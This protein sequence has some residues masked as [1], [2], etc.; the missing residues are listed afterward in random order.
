MVIYYRLKMVDAD[1]QFKYSNVVTIYLTE[2]T[3]VAISPNP[4]TGET[5]M[6]INA[7][8][9]GNV[10]WKLR[11]N[12]GRVVMQNTVGV[13]KGNNNVTINVNKLPVGLYYLHVTGAGIDQRVKLQKL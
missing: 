7:A 10:K 9:A 13:S 4:T 8:V 5:K 3:G 6:I 12:N 11:D 1:G 2:I